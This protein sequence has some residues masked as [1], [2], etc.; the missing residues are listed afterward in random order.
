[1]EYNLIPSGSYSLVTGELRNGS[2]PV[3]ASGNVL[4]IQLIA[5]ALDS[6]TNECAVRVNGQE[7][8]LS[9]ASGNLF[10]VDL[11]PRGLNSTIT[12]DW[13][14]GTTLAIIEIQGA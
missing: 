12:I 14:A 4:R 9:L 6:S 2:S 11:N 10:N 5:I 8:A 13:I 7:I 1:M 3:T